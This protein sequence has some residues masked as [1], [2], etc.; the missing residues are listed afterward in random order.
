LEA[1]GNVAR[2][3][4]RDTGPGIEPADLPRLFDRFYRADRAR[5]GDGTGLGLSIGRWIV[6]A[7]NGRITAA[8]A[9]GGGA[10]FTVT[11]P[12]SR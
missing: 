2:L 8:N 3:Q 9:P 1:H 4:V 7:H 12:L 6:E 10:L 11:L 5:T